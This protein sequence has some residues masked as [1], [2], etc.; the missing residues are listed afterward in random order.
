[1]QSGEEW[2]WSQRRFTANALTRFPR[3]ESSEQ[4]RISYEG[5]YRPTAWLLAN[6]AMCGPNCS[7]KGCEGLAN[8]SVGACSRKKCN[9]AQSV[10]DTL[11]RVPRAECSHIAALLSVHVWTSDRS[12]VTLRQLGKEKLQQT[13]NSTSTAGLQDCH[14]R[15]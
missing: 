11:L 9:L 2:R 1:M 10:D 15:R 8:K 3:M 14:C 13:N 5:A 4:I 12:S 7:Q 6:Q